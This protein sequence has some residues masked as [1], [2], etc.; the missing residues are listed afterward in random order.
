MKK[1]SD[2]TQTLRALVVA[3]FGHRPPARYKHQSH[4]QDRLQYT[5]P[6][7][8][9]QCNKRLSAH[10]NKQLLQS[11]TMRFGGYIPAVGEE[12][13]KN[14]GFSP[15]TTCKLISLLQFIYFLD[16]VCRAFAIFVK[17]FAVV[18]SFNKLECA[19]VEMQIFA[20]SKCKVALDY[21]ALRANCCT[22]RHGNI[23]SRFHLIEHCVIG[24][25]F[26][27]GITSCDTRRLPHSF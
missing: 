24:G 27:T 8:S 13:K 19:L 9:A 15:Q 14:A 21:I 20:D 4:R 12:L 7:T 1:R 5:E 18:K 25:V 26:F 10:R 6:L 22:E 16:D 2:E 3:R 17:R 23:I 11:S